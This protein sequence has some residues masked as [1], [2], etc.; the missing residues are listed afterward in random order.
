MQQF[1]PTQFWTGGIY[2]T[3]Y[4]RQTLEDIL[5]QVYDILLHKR[6]LDLPQWERK[7]NFHMKQLSNRAYLYKSMPTHTVNSHAHPIWP[8]DPATKFVKVKP[9][10][11]KAPLD[12][13]LGGWGGLG[14]SADS[15]SSF[16][17]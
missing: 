16:P 3:A 8:D 2:S 14:V 5:L 10:I 6:P 17:Y 15:K 1:A 11:V 9:G 12:M 7:K 13:V 4:R